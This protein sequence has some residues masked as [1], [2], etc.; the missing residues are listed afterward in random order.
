MK[1]FNEV[2]AESIE[3]ETVESA[4]EAT[5]ESIEE[6][7]VESADEEAATAESTVSRGRSRA[8]RSRKMEDH[9]PVTDET[10]TNKKGRIA[11]ITAGILALV[12]LI[13]GGAYLAMGQ[14]YKKVFFPNT[15]INGMDA[16]GKTV[17]EVQKMIASGIDGYVLMIEERDDKT[18]SI[19]KDD[20]KL[21][22]E[23]DGSLEKLL[24]A[25][26][27]TQWLKYK[28]NPSEYQ[29]ETM[30][31]Y[32]ETD[33]SNKL[34]SLDCMNKAL[35]VKPEDAHL[36]EYI[37]GKG[38][39]IVPEIMGNTIITD[40]VEK[41][42]TE[43]ITNLKETLSLETL[44]GYESPAVKRDNAS[45]T[46]LRDQM[47][48]Y[49]G[50]TINYKFGDKTETLNGDR[51]HEW[52][53]VN[54]DFTASVDSAKAASY[55]DE[56]AI[57]YDTYNKSKT[58][59]TS[60]G[61]TI[62]VSGGIYGWRMNRNAET[63]ALIQ[64]IEAG[65]S[66]ERE[67]VY[68]Q[69]AAAHSGNDY[70]STYIEINL[71]AQHLF[72]YKNG[73][74]IVESDFVSGNLSRGWGTPAGTYMLTYKERNATL[75]GEN[76]RT[77]VDYWMPFNGGIGMHDATWR[78]SFGGAIY[79]TSG[80]HGCVNLPHAVAKKIFDNIPSGTPVICY[81][82][83]GTEAAGTSSTKP[84]ETTAAP[85]EAPTTEPSTAVPPT[86][87]PD[88]PNAGAHPTQPQPQPTQP[89]P[90]PTQPQPQPTQPQ[91]Q[92]TQPQPTHA[93]AETT[94]PA[95]PGSDQGNHSGAGPGSV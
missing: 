2:T 19:S 42:I 92:P 45:L 53:V 6:E 14:K 32:D 54:G 36:S 39:D 17:E 51:I 75:K 57:T 1:D 55:V 73:S 66:G 9:L 28:M 37:S 88:G 69:K 47:N 90:Q 11:A 27:P 93:P 63:S 29:I 72:F 89:Q 8:K 79:K 21:R 94:A 33:F 5:V 26:K 59:K 44:G 30:I 22:P 83:A 15:Q 13:G 71:T 35:M 20:I 40:I 56:L 80:S 52:L 64:A 18:E 48:Q 87:A 86:K 61:P 38:Y 7:T 81:N 65:T 16:S 10:E 50:V 78:S 3:E 46:G 23:F 62:K 12:L 41:E 74:L 49:A 60:Y 82:L 31:A 91:P 68:A 34:Q 67:P 95:G 70:G 77:P 84:E 85:T 43:A 58:L 25:Q 4:G 76:Y 24:S